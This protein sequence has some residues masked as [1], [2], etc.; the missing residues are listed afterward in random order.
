MKDFLLVAAVTMLLAFVLGGLNAIIVALLWNW[1][2]PTIANGPTITYWEAWGIC[3]L[4]SLLFK[5]QLSRKNES[6]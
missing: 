6:T 5:N 3:I 1:L 2:V 4:C